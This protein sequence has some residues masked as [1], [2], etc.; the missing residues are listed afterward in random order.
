MTIFCDLLLILAVL[1]FCISNLLSLPGNWLMVA[2][3]A[4]YA[5]L[6]PAEDRGSLDWT[7]VGVAAALALVGEVV[8]TLAG[9]AGVKRVGGSRAGTVLAFFGSLAGAVAGMVL[10][11]PIP[12]VGSLI[13]A[14]LFA[15]LGALLG[16]V[17]GERLTGRDWQHSWTV[18]Q[19]A[20]RARLT[21]TLLKALIGTI[22]A[23][24]AIAAVFIA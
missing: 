1:A 12:V 24:L 8:E 5:W 22:I 7:M 20:F 23:G 6:M 9:A 17:L 14:V 10:G 15:C 13:A 4:L 11:L 18:G 21:G 19:A 2:A 3:M 16:A